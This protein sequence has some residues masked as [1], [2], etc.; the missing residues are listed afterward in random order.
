[1]FVQRSGAT[2]LVQRLSVPFF[3]MANS[4]NQ[5]DLCYPYPILIPR[6]FGDYSMSNKGPFQGI[7][8]PK[9]WPEYVKLATIHSVAL[10]HRVI[11]YSRS[12]A[13]NS[14]IERVRL[15]GELDCVQN[16]IALLHEELRIKDARMAKLPPRK[17][18]QYALQERMAILELKA[19]RV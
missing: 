6:S 1:M 14:S 8:L 11:T 18:P 17:R 9:D 16:E 15:A 2:V 7:P 10:A 5:S 19:A 3:W 12:F 4:I 13:I